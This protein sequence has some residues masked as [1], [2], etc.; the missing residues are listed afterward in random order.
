MV[1]EACKRYPNL[2]GAVFDLPSVAGVS[3]EYVAQAGLQ[4]RIEILQ[5]DF[6]RDEFPPADL[7][8]L[9]RILH[10]WSDNKVAQL[11]AKIHRQLPAK[12]GLLI[13]EKLLNEERDGPATAYLQS[14]NMLVVTE[15]KERSASEYEALTKAAGFRSFRFQRTG[16]PIDVMFAEK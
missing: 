15:G 6:F 3:T 11:L 1:I 10:D 12:G 2:R 16:Q 13:C 8:N 14:L 7:Y 9:G 5:G 4:D